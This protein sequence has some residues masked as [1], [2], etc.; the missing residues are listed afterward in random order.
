MIQWNWTNTRI[1]FTL[2]NTLLGNEWFGLPLDFSLSGIFKQ[3]I[4]M[5]VPKKRLKIKVL[6]YA[7]SRFYNEGENSIL[8]KVIRALQLTYLSMRC[9]L[10]DFVNSS[11]LMPTRQHTNWY[12]KIDVLSNA[13][14]VVKFYDWLTLMFGKFE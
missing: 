6:P 2:K 4:C 14:L 11:V 10:I 13:V 9:V 7:K 1:E 3:N 12:R 8:S 5:F